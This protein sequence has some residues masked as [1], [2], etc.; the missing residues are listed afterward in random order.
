VDILK[1]RLRIAV[2]VL[3]IAAGLAG[4]FLNYPLFFN[5]DFLFGSIFTMLVLQLFGW[6]WAVLTA[7]V[8]SSCTWYLWNHPYAIIIFTTEA[9]VVGLLTERRRM[10]LLLADTLF[11]VV[12]GMPLVLLFYGG[13]MHIE[14][15]GLIVI[16]LKQTLNGV[17][18]TLIACIAVTLF[19]LS[20]L[21]GFSRLRGVSFRDAILNVLAAFVLVPCLLFV[22]INGRTEFARI[23]EDLGARL[24]NTAGQSR[25]LLDSWLTEHLNVVKTLAVFAA[26]DPHI[27]KQLEA[28][29]NTDLHF[30]RIGLLN[31][32]A[33]TVAYAPLVDE[34]GKSTLGRSFA[35]RP[36]IPQ[37]KQTLQPAVSEVVMSRIGRPG[38]TVA[39][40]APVVRNNRYDGY[41]AGIV[42]FDA[43]AELLKNSTA[44]WDVRFSLL[45]QN[46]HVIVTSIPGLATMDSFDPARSGE[47]R[48]ISGSLFQWVPPV[49][50]N[51]AAMERWSRSFY[52]T[53][54]VPGQGVPWK[55]VLEAPV[56]P[57]Q[58]NLNRGY[59][60]GF[61]E[62]F[63]LFL[64]AVLI[65]SVLSRKLASGF[66]D[67]SD[68][69]AGL[70][71]RISRG[72]EVY[73]PQ[74]RFIETGRL[75]DNFRAMADSLAATFEELAEMN[76]NLERRAEERNAELR[77]S[78]EQLSLA[79]EGS[80]AGLW[81]WQVQT[82]E[83][84]FNERWA[85]MLGYSLKDLEPVSF[86]TRTGLCHPDDLARSEELLQKH[87]AGEMPAYECETRMRHRDGRWIWVLERGRVTEWDTAGRPVRMTGT[88]LDITERKQ[89][90]ERAQ[91]YSSDLERLLS[92]S[93]EMTSA[94]DLMRLYRAV[95]A[96][97]KELLRVDCSTVMLLSE[98]SG[99][100]TIVETI[101]FPESTIG[102]F[103][104]GEGEGL[105]PLVVKTGRPDTVRDYAA[106][107]RFSVPSL[108]SQNSLR[109]AVCAPLIAQETVLGVLI[110]HS[111]E[112]RTFGSDEIALYQN[113]A[114]QAAVAIRNAMNLDA[115]RRA[116]KKLRDVTSHIGEGLYVFDREGRITF[117]NNEAERLLGWTMDE[118]NARGPHELVHN[119]RA[120]GTPLP[121]EECRIHNMAY[122]G[123]HYFSTDEVF[124]RKDGTVFP[125]LVISS[126]I[127]EGGQVVAS[128]TAFREISDVKRLETE[129]LK[130]Q[131][132]DSIAVLAGGIAHD[133]NNLLQAILGNISLAR[134]YAPPGTRYAERLVQAEQATNQAKELSY[135]LLTFSK[136]G[137]PVRVATDI[138]R[139]LRESVGLALSG[140]NILA[141]FDLPEGLDPVLADGNQLRQVFHNLT[142]NAKEAMPSGGRLRISAK[143]LTVSRGDGFPLREGRYVLISVTDQGCGIPRKDRAR[144]FD[145][146]FTTKEVGSERGR[147]L[148]LAVCHSIIA[149][150]DGA[151]TVESE[152]GQGTTFHIFLPAAPGARE[153]RAAPARQEEAVHTGR[154]LLMDDE[155]QVQ[156]V[157]GEMLKQAGYDVDLARNGEEAIAHYRRAL[158]SGSRYDLVI[159]DLTIP[160]GMG[161]EAAIEQI[162]A[163]DPAVTAVVSSGYADSPVMKQSRKYGFAAAI[164]KPFDLQ[165]LLQVLSRLQAKK[166]EL[167]GI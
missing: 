123:R 155:Q 99:R 116:E 5:V 18:N 147:G 107:T 15:S 150:H 121:F 128:V 105:G 126:P 1:D 165:Q 120:D 47:T 96:A 54:I 19:G 161:G 30:L 65:A 11:W 145:P 119:R 33:V 74:S 29:R 61:A 32:D 62:A 75:I 101:G 45:D 22:T 163:M 8:A 38:P 167:P 103:S 72:Q 68:V 90:E 127:Y 118:M 143:N 142:L 91:K 140:S 59:G 122:S 158:T 134:R 14:S 160:A 2:L 125:I 153:L 67:L 12:M 93:R 152:E 56:A 136:G 146:Y 78:R 35:D 4:N 69:T 144:I 94:T 60:R 82:G 77:R 83:A 141:E 86:R 36:F 16:M 42:N 100:L 113:I 162:R 166:T 104:L 41:V 26:R 130:A 28:V 151:I 92:V 84:V 6:R 39:M 24:M 95:A 50:K 154:I 70:P 52:M 139:P 17:L 55:L 135:R 3:L 117:M 79:L 23:E 89:T 46:S 164:A 9:F 73:W 85:E 49:K 106:E 53:E 64:L 131:K 21:T 25:A 156:S 66:S 7:A 31:R 40:L 102:T 137:E 71:G 109:S 80:G 63:C 132:L 133:F 149:K 110:G 98:D 157:V 10:S 87:F 51:V 13:V 112:L 138:A 115:A 159:L 76:E 88:Q 81:D 37:L 58:K 108:V 27:Q 57:F 111:R 48:A 124:V 20:G 114:N 129:M 44:G 43:L 148:G 97:S 34:L